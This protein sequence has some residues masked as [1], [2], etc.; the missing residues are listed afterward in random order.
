MKKRI[1]TT[2]NVRIG[3]KVI[4]GR[5]WEYGD[6]E[7]DSK[8]GIIIRRNDHDSQWLDGS[9]WYIVRWEFNSK[10]SYWNQE[11]SYRVGHTD[12]DSCDLYF[13]EEDLIKPE[14]ISAVKK[15]FKVNKIESVTREMLLEANLEKYLL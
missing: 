12:S 5:D 3:L 2:D 14:F 13:Y 10:S 6:Q 9:D 8:Y 1:I 4:R 11:N 7:H 15:H